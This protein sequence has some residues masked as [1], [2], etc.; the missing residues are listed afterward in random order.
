MI[1]VDFICS[2]CGAE[3]HIPKD[4]Y[5]KRI[6]EGKGLCTKCY[7]NLRC[8]PTDCP[9]WIVKWFRPRMM[10]WYKDSLKYNNKCIITGEESNIIHHPTSFATLVRQTYEELGLKPTDTIDCD[11]E[12][13]ELLVKKCLEIH[14]KHG[15]GVCMSNRVHRLFHR[16]YGQVQNTPQQL[17]EFKIMMRLGLWREC[18]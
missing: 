9:A 13:D 5:E 12:L 4:Y 11:K 3:A 15:Y 17:E 8:A 2:K 7:R 18:L 1:T 14:Y 6:E 16:I 10:Q